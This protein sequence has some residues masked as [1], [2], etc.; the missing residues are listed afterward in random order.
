VHDAIR[1]GDAASLDVHSLAWRLVGAA[2]A[3][4]AAP[5]FLDRE[6]REQ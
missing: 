6:I 3:S 5:T 1:I 4:A 2:V